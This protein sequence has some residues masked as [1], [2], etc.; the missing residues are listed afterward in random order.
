MQAESKAKR[1]VT[2]HCRICWCNSGK[3]GHRKLMDKLDGDV[4]R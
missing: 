1:R 3:F 2:V 4:G